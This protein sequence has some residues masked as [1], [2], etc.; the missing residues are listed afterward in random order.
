MHI[1][2]YGLY[3]HVVDSL[4]QGFLAFQRWLRRS[5]SGGAPDRRGHLAGPPAQ[6]SLVALATQKNVNCLLHRTL[7]HKSRQFFLAPYRGPWRLTTVVETCFDSLRSTPVEHG[8]VA[9]EANA[10]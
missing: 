7:W 1:Y 4:F 3:T 2:T 9:V 10:C 5:P 6:E 8:A